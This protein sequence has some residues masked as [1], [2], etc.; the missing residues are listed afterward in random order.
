MEPAVG[1]EPTTHG[2]QNRCSAAELSWPGADDRPVRN[3]RTRGGV[4]RSGFSTAS[5]ILQKET[6]GT[7]GFGLRAGRGKGFYRRERR[8]ERRLIRNDAVLE[9]ELFHAKADQGHQRGAKP[10]GVSIHRTVGFDVWIPTHALDLL[11]GLGPPANEPEGR[12]SIH[13]S[14]D[15]ADFSDVGRH[16]PKTLDG[17]R[18]ASPSVHLR[19][20]RHLR[21]MLPRRFIAAWHP[22]RAGRALA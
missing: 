4:S 16:Q 19:N 17:L 2:L 18:H 20:L 13:L 5:G 10:H 15:D 21:T 1:I 7:K 8:E 22:I 12:C 6:N 14:A 3:R 9:A 11:A